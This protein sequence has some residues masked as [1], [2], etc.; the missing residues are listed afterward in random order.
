MD[1]AGEGFRDL[2]VDL[3]AEP[4]QAAEGGLDVPARAAEAV[5]EVEMAE[6]GVEVVPPHQA[7]YAPA[8]PNAFGVA[9]RAADGL[10]R[11]DELVGLALIVLVDVGVGGRRLAG[12][13]LGRRGPAL[14]KGAA[15]SD[16]EGDA[17]GSREM[18]QPG[19]FW[20]KHPCTHPF[21]D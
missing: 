13:I 9:G 16:Q 4:G 21:P 7:D 5:V 2:G 6:G 3:P 15:G 20:I 19:K 14:G 18:A 8:K 1:A 11:L 10:R 17:R 12:L